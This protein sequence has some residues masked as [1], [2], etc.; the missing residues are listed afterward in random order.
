MTQPENRSDRV[1]QTPAGGGLNGLD[2]AFEHLLNKCNPPGGNVLEQWKGQ[3]ESLVSEC[4]AQVGQSAAPG[5]LYRSVAPGK[6]NV[7]QMPA[8]LE[9]SEVAH[10]KFAAPDACVRAVAGS[11]SRAAPITLPRKPLSAMQLAM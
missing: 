11:A 6:R 3:G 10:E 1:E 2:V 8:P 5:L 7:A 9:T 4:G